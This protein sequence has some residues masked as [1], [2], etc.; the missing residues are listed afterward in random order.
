MTCRFERLVEL[1]LLMDVLYL[2]R[3]PLLQLFVRQTNA[4]ATASLI[5]LD[6]W[7][8]AGVYRFK[9]RPR[10]TTFNG[11]FSKVTFQVLQWNPNLVTIVLAEVL[12]RSALFSHYRVVSMLLLYAWNLIMGFENSSESSAALFDE[13]WLTVSSA[14]D[15]QTVCSIFASLIDDIITSETQLTLF[16]SFTVNCMALE[17]CEVK[18]L[19]NLLIRVGAYITL[20]SKKFRAW[21]LL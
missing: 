17:H 15:W 19:Y 5:V 7:I 8:H 13:V 1:A 2:I 4:E 14:L 3:C 21:F 11:F 6:V 20:S 9:L 10:S 18:R 12:F 16:G